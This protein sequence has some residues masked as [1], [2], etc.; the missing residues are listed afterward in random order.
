MA[1]FT[2][3]DVPRLQLKWAFGFPGELSADAQPTVAGGRVFV[4]T[5][6]GTVYSLS[7]ATGCV[8]WVFQAAAA[9]RAAVS[10]RPRRDGGPDHATRRSSVT[11]PRTSTRSM[12][13]TGR[14]AVDDESGRFRVRPGDR[15]PGVAQ[16][17]PLCRR[18]LRRRDG[19]R[20]G[21]LRVLPI[22]RQPGRAERRDGRTDLEDVHDRRRAAADDEE[23][24]RHAVVGAVGR[25]DLDRARPSTS[26]G[27]P[28]TSPPATT[29][30]IRHQHQRCVRG[31]RSRFRQDP[32]VPPD[33]GGRRL[34]HLLPPAGQDQLHQCRRT[35]FRFRLSADPG[36]ARP[37]AG[38][39]S[40]PDRN[41]ASSTPSI[42]IAR[43][44]SSGRSASARAASTAACSGV[45]PPIQANVYVALSDIGRIPVPN[46]QAH[47]ARSE[48]RR[49]DVR[50]PPRQRSAGLAH[51][52]AAMWAARTLQ[53]RSIGC[54]QCHSRC[55]VFR[56]GRRTPPRLFRDERRHR[57]GL[58]YGP[59]RT[60]P[61]TVCRGVAVR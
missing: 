43:A 11:A 51:A 26:S 23:Q 2:A 1:G 15:R 55:G 3:A 19:R 46:S 29:T 50:T 10:D 39:R 35:R 22:P 48:G 25:A 40:W 61:S 4:G 33:D 31:I 32:L 20:H 28:S 41:P 30:A 14:A 9:V 5:Q 58:R 53:S 56:I 52:A 13:P 45:R 42:P 18:R 37:T 49:R 60:T 44:R 59:D 36:D 6:S 8:H 47:G 12:R 24:D 38:A 17:A 16:R 21:R 57:V 34:E 27:T 7:A 54:G